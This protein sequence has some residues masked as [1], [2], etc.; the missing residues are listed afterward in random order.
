MSADPFSSSLPQ[1][2]VN[3]LPRLSL[4]IFSLCLLLQYQPLLADGPASDVPE[5]M[6]LK[7]FVG[8]WEGKDPDGQKTVSETEWTLNGRFIKQ[9]Y[10]TGEK[11]KGMIMRG[12]SLNENK[13]VMTIFDS[14]GTA[15][16]MSGVWNPETKTLTCS[17]D[18][19]D[20][21]KMTV[22]SSFPNPDIEAYK[23]IVTVD[24]DV[25]NEFTGENHRVRSK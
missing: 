3:M 14:S 25:V 2:P 9:E 19:A 15:I 10:S 4:S 7:Q 16:T 17:G 20:G 22:K 11:T 1:E 5:L 13:Y 24:G 21:I 8:N 18:L 23:I 6:V 12:Y